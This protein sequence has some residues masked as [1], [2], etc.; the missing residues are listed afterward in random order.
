MEEKRREELETE[1]EEQKTR[2]Q[3]QTELEAL[4]AENESLKKENKKWREMSFSEAKE[5]LYDKVPLTLRQMDIL[6][7]VLVGLAVLFTVLGMK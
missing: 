5:N 7:A 2:A 1:T 4:Q 3:L 6:I